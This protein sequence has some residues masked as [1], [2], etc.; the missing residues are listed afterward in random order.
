MIIEYFKEGAVKKVYQRFDEKG[1][2]MPAGVTYI[3]S[4]VESNY[5]RCF[6]VME[7]PD[8]ESLD[9]WISNW[10]DLVDFEVIPVVTTKEAKQNLLG[11]V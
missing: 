3:N 11:A 9:E 10:Q 1:R 5:N 6:Q 2:M 4:W 7:C 8:K